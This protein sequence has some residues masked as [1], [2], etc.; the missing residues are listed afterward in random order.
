MLTL[1]LLH[2]ALGAADP[3]GASFNESLVGFCVE[4]GKNS[5]TIAEFDVDY[6]KGKAL[7]QTLSFGLHVAI[8]D[9]SEFLKDP[10]KAGVCTGYAQAWGLT[11]DEGAPVLP[12]GKINIFDGGLH[13]TTGE[14][15]ELRMEYNLPFVALDKKI[16]TLTGIKHM[17]GDHCLKIASQITTLYVH[18]REGNM[19]KTGTIV[20]EGVVHIGVVAAAKLIASLRLFGGNDISRV[21]GLV[22][23]G[24]F[25]GQDV[26]TNCDPHPELKQTSVD[27]AW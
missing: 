18:V 22:D 2:A 24:L 10:M 9:I 3:V 26:L 8:P 5:T 25:L 4:G 19:N 12:G 14:N 23:F 27:Y 20:R 16:Y 7:N 15:T 1:A 11:P 13:P 6:T 21:V 17:P